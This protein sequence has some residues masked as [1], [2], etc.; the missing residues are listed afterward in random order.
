MSHHRARAPRRPLGGGQEGDTRPPPSTPLVLSPGGFSPESGL[1][2]T[3]R[4]TAEEVDFSLS[5]SRN[6]G[7]TS[8]P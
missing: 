8:R 6:G 7:T 4:T 3:L 2:P 1:T 5:L